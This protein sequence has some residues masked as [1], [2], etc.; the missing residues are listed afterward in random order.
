M[1]RISNP[2]VVDFL[3]LSDRTHWLHPR[4]K[5]ASIRSKPQLLEDL[6]RHFRT[7]HT[8]N[9]SRLLF[10]PLRS[11][12]TVP[13]IEYCFLKKL[14]LFDGTPIDV[15]KKSKLRVPFRIVKGPVVVS[16]PQ[17]VPR[18]PPE[19]KV[20]FSRQRDAVTYETFR[21]QDTDFLPGCLAP[22]LLYGCSG[23]TPKRVS[24]DLPAWDRRTPIESPMNA[25]VS[26]L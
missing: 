25:D 17:I 24:C 21:R 7:R 12:P 2:H 22:S 26:Y 3:R 8:K 19:P 4:I 16:F 1:E 18:S 10:L 20:D 15:P 6:Q 5:Y 9:R 14:F 23:R 13:R 11:L